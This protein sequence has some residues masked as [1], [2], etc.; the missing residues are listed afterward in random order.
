MPIIKFYTRNRGLHIVLKSY[1]CSQVLLPPKARGTVTYLAPPGN[2]TIKDKIL[3]TEF[4]GEKTE[5]TLMQVSK[6][7]IAYV[8]TLNRQIFSIFRLRKI[9]LYGTTLLFYI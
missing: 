2:Y 5:Y 3:E 8:V 4:D 7:L 1:F 6:K 9:T